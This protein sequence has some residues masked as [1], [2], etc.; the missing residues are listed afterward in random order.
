MGMGF[1]S[2]KNAF[3]RCPQNWRSRFRPQNCGQTLYGHEDFSE[4]LI[5]QEFINCNHF[6]ADSNPGTS[7]S[8]TFDSKSMDWCS[9]LSYPI[10]LV[11]LLE[12][13]FNIAGCQMV[14]L[15]HAHLLLGVQ[16]PA[17]F[18]LIKA[19]FFLGFWSGTKKLPV[20]V[21]KGKNVL[22]QYWL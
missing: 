11:L 6:G 3:S 17:F 16:S 10:F 9:F 21:L 20:P 19:V 14:F 15:Q 13:H 7:R 12:H 18:L 5:G 22:H 2:R 1:S 8:E 4:F